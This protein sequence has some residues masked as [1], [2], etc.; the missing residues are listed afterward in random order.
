M[1]KLL[2]FTNS[3]LILLC[4]C[5]ACFEPQEGCL[6]VLATNYDVS[7]DEPCADCCEYPKLTLE[8]EHMMG[9]TSLRYGDP[10]SLDAVHFFKMARIRFYISDLRLERAGLS[11]G[12]TD[13]LQLE[14]GLGTARVLQSIEDNF[15]L[16][17]RNRFSFGLGRFQEI[18][19][20]DSLRFQVG[21]GLPA[22]TAD[23]ADLPGGHPLAPQ[24]D[25]M[26]WSLDSGYIY[27][28]VLLLRDT[29]ASTD[30]TWLS[31][32]FPKNLVEVVLPYGRPVT[33]G[34]DVVVPLRI[35]YMEWL[36][37]INFV[38]DTEEQMIAKIVNNTAKAFNI[39]P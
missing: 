31:I 28:Q 11:V 29:F 16:I 1:C 5:S 35:D 24:T 23:P 27:N 32:G 18:G 17:Q 30:T 12:S 26:H 39:N 15:A 4:I 8:V 36:E 14:L 13:S 38:A 33:L 22:N 20:F 34:F 3:C 37:G 7:A 10:Y 2:I 25:S 9:D 6:D 19:T 21:V